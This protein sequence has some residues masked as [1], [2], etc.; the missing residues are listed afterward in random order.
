MKVN[1]Y[2]MSDIAKE[3]DEY[4]INIQDTEGNIVY[5]GDKYDLITSDEFGEL[6]IL[7]VEKIKDEKLLIF[8]TF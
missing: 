4:T 7:D 5:Y 8:M 6:L 1:E 2:L 3:Y